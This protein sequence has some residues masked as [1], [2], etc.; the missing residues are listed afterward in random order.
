MIVRSL[1]IDPSVPS[2]LFA[3]TQGGGIFK[4]SNAGTNWTAVNSGLPN[5]T[6]LSLVIDPSASSTFYAGTQGGAFKSSSRAVRWQPI[7][8][9]GPAVSRALPNDETQTPSLE[10]SGFKI[11][12]SDVQPGATRDTIM[13]ALRT[14]IDRVNE[15]TVPKGTSDFFKSVKVIVATPQDLTADSSYDSRTKTVTL[16]D[17]VWITAADGPILLHELIHAYHDQRLQG[18]GRNPDVLRLYN[19]AAS[20]HLF[21]SDSYM[22]RNH[23]EYLAQMA[24]IYLRG[25]GGRDPF[26]RE[27]IRMKQ[28]DCYQWL[29][30]EFGP[31]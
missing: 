17:A 28:P 30:N 3:G 5:T 19:E 13:T 12:I 14:Q 20:N 27:N 11:D 25:Q 31:R 21:P 10:Y 1:V 26:T 16:R 8:G 29:E 6:V 23:L 9:N 4:T 22:M 2:T 18:A 24:V 7:G 15:V